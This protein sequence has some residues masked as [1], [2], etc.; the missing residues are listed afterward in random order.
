M[1]LVKDSTVA[2]LEKIVTNILNIL[3]KI[4]KS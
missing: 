1:D 2:E 4:G 3:D